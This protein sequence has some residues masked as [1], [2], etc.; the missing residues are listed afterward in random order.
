MSAQEVNGITVTEDIGQIR[1]SRKMTAPTP[2]IA[3]EMVMSFG[4]PSEE[5]AQLLL[6][7][8]KCD[9]LNG[10]FKAAI[11]R[12]LN[13]LIETYE[14]RQ[15]PPEQGEIDEEW[16]PKQLG[17]SRDMLVYAELDLLDETSLRKIS[18]LIQDGQ[19]SDDPALRELSRLLGLA[20]SPGLQAESGSRVIERTQN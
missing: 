8:E 6:R 14:Q 1:A 11:K 18:G 19:S 16:E 15:V 4:I 12:A 2:G 7:Y 9:Y 5:L 10:A 20:I 17:L 3:S 13:H